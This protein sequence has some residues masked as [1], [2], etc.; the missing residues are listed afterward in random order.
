MQRVQS[1]RNQMRMALVSQN[2]IRLS[3]PKHPKGEMLTTNLIPKITPRISFQGKNQPTQP[4]T[5]VPS[6]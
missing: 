2:D 3:V 1:K 4:R 6:C 5:R